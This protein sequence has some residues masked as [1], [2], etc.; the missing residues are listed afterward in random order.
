MQLKQRRGPVAR[1]KRRP[2]AAAQVVAFILTFVVVKLMGQ[3]AAESYHPF[4]LIIAPVIAAFI[5]DKWTVPWREVLKWI[6]QN[7]KHR[8]HRDALP[9]DPRDW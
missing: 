4:I 7:N 2:H 1:I 5:A 3:D 8:G 6:E 9:P